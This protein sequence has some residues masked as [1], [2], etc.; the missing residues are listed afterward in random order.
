MKSFPGIINRFPWKE[1]G[2][3]GD[4]LCLASAVGRRQVKHHSE[5]HKL[6]SCDA[7]QPSR[8]TDELHV[9]LQLQHKCHRYVCSTDTTATTWGKR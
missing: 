5:L 7:E 3:D 1:D 9:E 4:V 2:V 6:Q 8:E